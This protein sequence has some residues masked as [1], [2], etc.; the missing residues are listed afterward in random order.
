VGRAEEPQRQKKNI[1]GVMYRPPNSS[2][3][4][5]HK[6]HHKIERACKKGKVTVI[7]EHFNMQVDWE[8]YVRSGY[9]EREFMKCLRDGFLEQLVVEPT[10]EQAIL[11]LVLCNEADLIKELK[12]KEPLGRVVII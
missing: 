7:M 5:G 6:I 3:N 12:V 11:D 8:N 10:R 2:Q 9:Q 1:M 4:L